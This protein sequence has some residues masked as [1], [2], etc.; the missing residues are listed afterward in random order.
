M[1]GLLWWAHAHSPPGLVPELYRH[2]LRDGRCLLP[3]VS[4][5]LVPR[6]SPNA[7]HVRARVR[8]PPARLKSWLPPQ[9]RQLHVEGTLPSRAP[10][11]RPYHFIAPR[12][13]EWVSA[14]PAT[15]AGLPSGRGP[16]L[17]IGLR[18]RAITPPPRPPVPGASKPLRVAPLLAAA[19]VPAPLRA[20][21]PAIAPVR[22][23]RLKGRRWG[24]VAPLV[25]PTATT[26]PRAAPSATKAEIRV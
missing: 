23:R 12:L 3:L 4:L 14:I 15:A 6:P 26:S 7:P 22:G 11:L 13:K 16:C 8:D 24:P 10:P 21:I 2:A 9:K 5:S 25:G 17:I 19:R 20:S 1:R 18:P